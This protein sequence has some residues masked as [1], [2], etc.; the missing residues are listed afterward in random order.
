MSF[1]FGGVALRIV[2]CPAPLIGLPNTRIHPTM[3]ASFGATSRTVFPAKLWTKRW[4]I[5]S[6]KSRSMSDCTGA[7][8]EVIWQ[9]NRNPQRSPRDM[10][11]NRIS[12]SA[13]QLDGRS[14]LSKDPGVVKGPQP[15]NS[16]PTLTTCASKR[17]KT[18]R[19]RTLRVL[20]P[21]SE[22]ERQNP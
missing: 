15:L 9:V 19:F 6:G 13:C 2:T 14:S 4:I 10:N 5:V 21:G 11:D 7:S 17:M 20:P 1:F 22:C 8:L 3:Q 12:Q 16:I 18:V